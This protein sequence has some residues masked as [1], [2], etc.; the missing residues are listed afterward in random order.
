MEPT[1]GS[2]LRDRLFSPNDATQAFDVTGDVR[3]AVATWDPFARIIS[4]AIEQEGDQ[5]KLF[6]DYVDLRSPNE[7]RG[8][9]SFSI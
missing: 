3:D 2:R 8:R 9:V 1:F 4:S 6:I 7:D 5:I